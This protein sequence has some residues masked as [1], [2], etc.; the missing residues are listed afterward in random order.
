[1]SGA[2]LAMALALTVGTAR[3]GG[4]EE[5]AL[6]SRP[7]GVETS[8]V[9]CEPAGRTHS[10][11]LASPDRARQ[12]WAELAVT[13]AG[14]R[15]RLRWVLHVSANSGSSF[16]AVTVAEAPPLGEKNAYVF[17]LV[18]FTDAGRR[19]LG[20]RNESRGDWTSRTVVVYDFDT[21]AVLMQD[22]DARVERLAPDEGPVYGDPIG[23]VSD[24]TVALVVASSDDV[25]DVFRCWPEAQW[26]LNVRTGELRRLS[27]AARV[28]SAGVPLDHPTGR[29]TSGSR[30]G[31]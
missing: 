24:D 30:P 28:V 19:V 25:D 16:T 10:R 8:G 4:A 23:F 6:H 3:A 22:V 15:C 18:G 29:Q 1:M 13:R 7:P 12:V 21:R 2:R 14:N 20:V 5:Q 27:N 17:E 11:I 26:E 31:P 9:G